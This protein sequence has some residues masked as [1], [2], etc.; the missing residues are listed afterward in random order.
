MVTYLSFEDHFQPF[1]LHYHKDY[2]ISRIRAGVEVI[3]LKDKRYLGRKD[4]VTLTHPYEL[5]AN[6]LYNDSKPV[7]FDTLYW[8]ISDLQ[9]YAPR[10][11]LVYFEQHVWQH[12]RLQ[13][14]FDTVL[15][16]KACDEQ[17][18]KAFLALLVEVGQGRTPYLPQQPLQAWQT[19]DNYIDDHIYQRIHLEEL[20]KI[21]PMNKFGFA[22]KFKKQTGLSPVHYVLMKK[23]FHA[24]DHLTH[25]SSIR[26]IA[27]QYDFVDGAHF[28][29]TF[30]RFIGVSP[31]LY[32][33][34]MVRFD[35][36]S[37]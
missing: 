18:L 30:K 5:H 26:D 10:N 12:T 25:Q 20:A 24:K 8:S 7:S 17:A 31:K 29:K 21:V 33:D 1:P 9:R 28:S 3:E 19:L 35:P 16:T 22:R 27:Y 4:C 11:A 14:L 15:A 34:K 32:C 23:V 2:C 37:R 36:K 13:A 6:P